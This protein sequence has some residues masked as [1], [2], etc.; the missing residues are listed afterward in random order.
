VYILVPFFSFPL[1]LFRYIGILIPRFACLLLIIIYRSSLCLVHFFTAIRIKDAFFLFSL[2][3]DTYLDRLCYLIFYFFIFNLSYYTIITYLALS[4]AKRFD[5]Y[6]RR[7]INPSIRP[8]ST[9]NLELERL[10]LDRINWNLAWVNRSLGIDALFLGGKKDTNS[11]R[12]DLTNL[13][14]C[15]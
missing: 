4:D 6:Y 3:L 1:S 7:I 2:L 8:S 14:K 9:D 13:T 11:Y 15:G 12:N 5:K 10:E